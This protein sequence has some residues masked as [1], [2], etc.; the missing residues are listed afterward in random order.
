MQERKADEDEIG[1]M[2]YSQIKER[3]L[4]VRTL[5]D[6]VLEYFA[7]MLCGELERRELVRRYKASNN[8]LSSNVKRLNKATA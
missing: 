4:R 5:P 1:S 2:K 6:Y 3:L 7:P 8:G